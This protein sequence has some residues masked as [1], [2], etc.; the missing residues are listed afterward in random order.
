MSD[1]TV[2]SRSAGL[3]GRVARFIEAPRVQQAVLAVIIVNGATLGLETSATAMQAAGG[4]ILALDRIALVI[5]VVELAAKL[6]A[7]RGSFFRSGWN[8]FD[9][10]V[11]AIGLAPASEGFTVLRALRVLR[12]LR[13]VSG[14]PSMRTVVHALLSAIPGLG[15][16]IALLGLVYY[17]AAVIAT[18]LYGPSFPDWFGSVGDSAYSLFQIMTLES[19]SMGIVRPV[20]EVYPQ[21]WLFFV[22]FILLTSFTVLNLFIAVVV[23]AMQS[24]HDAERAVAEGQARD[25]RA[26]IAAG[27]VALRADVARIEAMLRERR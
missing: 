18:K 19:W 27:I 22:A 23:N 26:E 6:Y 4:L 10:I 11:V 7:W 16:I 3:R 5:F 9:L 8:V 21:A 12:V 2:F 14:V 17:V 25:K 15:S 20:M 1:A 13:L 24:Q